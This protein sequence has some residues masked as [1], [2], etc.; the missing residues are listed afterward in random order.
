M[1]KKPKA[2]A[3]G[4]CTEAAMGEDGEGWLRF[5]AKGVFYSPHKATKCE[6]GHITGGGG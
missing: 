4:M 6:L 3:A 1:K 2:G 5:A